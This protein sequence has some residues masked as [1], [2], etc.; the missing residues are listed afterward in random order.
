M[1]RSSL[2]PSFATY[3]ENELSQEKYPMI[4]ARSLT[5]VAATILCLTTA[6]AQAAIIHQGKVTG[7]GAWQ[8]SI[9]DAAG[10]NETFE[11]DPKA[12]IVHNGKSATLDT[13]DSGDVAKLTLKTKNGKLVVTIIDA[14]D[15]E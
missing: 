6:V 14:R 2:K 7:V 1:R 15:R 9:V 5:L 4:P 10:D 13:I 12:Q 8:I 3:F 11:V